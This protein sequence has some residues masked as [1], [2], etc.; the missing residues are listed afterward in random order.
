MHACMPIMEASIESMH[1]SSNT[2]IQTYI[3]RYINRTCVYVDAH[4]CAETPSNGRYREMKFMI[5][6]NL[7]I[8]IEVKIIEG[9]DQTTHQ[10]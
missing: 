5:Y 2:Y 6:S 1:E 10:S 7:K 4:T 8:E 9:E 3:H